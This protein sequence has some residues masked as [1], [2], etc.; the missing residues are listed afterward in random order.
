[1]RSLTAALKRRPRDGGAGGIRTLGGSCPPHWISNPAPSAAR[2]R[3][4]KRCQR[5]RGTEAEGFEPPDTF[6]PSVFKTDALNHS[7]TP[8]KTRPAGLN[9][10]YSHVKR[11]AHI[12][13]TPL[14]D[15]PVTRPEYGPY[16][17]R[18]AALQEFEW[19][20]RLVGDSRARPAT[21]GLPQ[22]L[23]H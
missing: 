21:H 8:P 3:L 11:L 10:P 1:M 9:D 4:R 22:A 15:G 20:R 23:T 7:A 16:P 14:Q 19:T 2:S 12:G 6:M 13:T 5:T 18:A 17:Y